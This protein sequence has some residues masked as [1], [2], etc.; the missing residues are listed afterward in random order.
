MNVVCKD[1]KR[2][3]D[4]QAIKHMLPKTSS[5]SDWLGRYYTS[6][7]I[8]HLLVSL[9]MP[10]QPGTIV[11]LGS[12]DGALA[13]AAA[14]RWRDSH[15]IT[16]DIDRDATA[17]RLITDYNSSFKHLHIKA[18][19]LALDL[20]Q[21]IGVPLGSVDAAVCNPPYIRLPW[22]KGYAELLE[23]VGLSNAYPA[24]KEASADVIFIAQNLRLLRN[25]GQLGLIVPDGLISGE[26]T[27]EVRK[28]LI[29]QHQIDCVIKLPR[30]V[31]IGT[32]AQTHIVLLSK[33]GKENS[34]I[35]LMELNEYGGL[36]EPILISPEEGVKR[37]DYSYFYFRKSHPTGDEHT[38]NRSLRHLGVSLVRGS[39]NS[40]QAK[41]ANFP[42]FHTPNFINRFDH[43][44]NVPN[45]LKLPKSIE[46]SSN[47]VKAEPGDILLAR[48][49][50]G[51]EKKVCMIARGKM[52]I[53]DCV[54]RLRAPG[55]LRGGIVAALASDLGHD[56]LK[57]ISHGVGAKHL[58]MQDILDF[59]PT[60]IRLDIT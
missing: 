39:L 9:M 6:E 43:M 19:A 8:S 56:Y 10:E 41:E 18:D 23:E 28:V 20:P 29:E 42:V 15:L 36:S 21:Q 13:I 12:G 38:T 24:I 58:S 37:L 26:K 33:F 53:T 57:S 34:M 40:R 52:A 11:D 48:V 44:Y 17:S 1:S 4:M 59:T 14:C 2:N 7:A 3:K 47:I 51:L 35:K 31:F 22:R 30:R 60:N 16:V 46:L 55:N 25:G 27:A 54:Y 5:G 49:G 32:E 45:D 50:R